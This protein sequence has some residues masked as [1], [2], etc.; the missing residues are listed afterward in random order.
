[1]FL[2]TVTSKHREY[3]V[4][5]QSCNTSLKWTPTLSYRHLNHYNSERET[6]CETSVKW[7]PTLSMRAIISVILR[8]KQVLTDGDKQHAAIWCQT[9]MI[10][11]TSYLKI[12][13]FYPLHDDLRGCL[14]ANPCSTLLLN[15]MLL[16]YLLFSLMK[17]T[18]KYIRCLFGRVVMPNEPLRC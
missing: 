13:L 12:S 18:G 14:R 11:E 9:V 15:S 17:G 16:R 2:R 4:I 5:E 6:K 3:L 10:L 1:M 7:P 8:E